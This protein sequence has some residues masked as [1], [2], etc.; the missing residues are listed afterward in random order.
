[1]IIDKIIGDIITYKEDNP[2]II[3]TDEIIKNLIE[4]YK[5]EMIKKIKEGI[6]NYVSN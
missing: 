2:H 4:E 3:I 1:M 6:E 5:Q